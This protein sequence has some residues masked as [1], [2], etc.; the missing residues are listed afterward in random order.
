M[1]VAEPAA[2]R[3]RYTVLGIC[4]DTVAMPEPC[5][6]AMVFDATGYHGVA[7]A[8]TAESAA[9]VA[10]RNCAWAMEKDYGGLRHEFDVTPACEARQ[11][12]RCRDDAGGG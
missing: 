1:A 9:A 12:V 7:I 11:L 3:Y 10:E 4:G 8:S 5:P 2:P 6:L